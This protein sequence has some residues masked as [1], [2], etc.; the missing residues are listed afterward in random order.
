MVKSI[1][2]FRCQVFF[3]NYNNEM[4]ERF[5]GKMP[6]ARGKI[7]EAKWQEAKSGWKD[8]SFASLGC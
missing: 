2:V 7:Q 5:L 1:A 3:R 4:G 8:H 6:G